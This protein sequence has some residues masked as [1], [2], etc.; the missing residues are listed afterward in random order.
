MNVVVNGERR[1]AGDATTVLDIVRSLGTGAEVG[2][3]V[4]I[5]GEVVSK[6]EWSRTTLK[7]GDAVEVLRAIGGG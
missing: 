6:N 3:A 2:V 5:N 7:D 4:A 1:E